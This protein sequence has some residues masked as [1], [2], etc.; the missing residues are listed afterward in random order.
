MNILGTQNV[1][2]K[3]SWRDF[4]LGVMFHIVNVT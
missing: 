4:I 3:Q 1:E 2:Y